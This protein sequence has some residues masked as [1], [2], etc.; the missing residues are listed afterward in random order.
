[1]FFFFSFMCFV[2]SFCCFVLV[3]VGLMFDDILVFVV[4]L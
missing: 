2:L 1:M 3:F 4:V